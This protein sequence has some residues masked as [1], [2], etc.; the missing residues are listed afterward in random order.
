MVI[1]YFLLKG[2]TL[3]PEDEADSAQTSVFTQQITK[4]HISEDSN[5]HTQYNCE[6]FRFSLTH[7]GCYSK[8]IFWVLPLLK[9]TN[10]Y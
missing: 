3:L 10:L 6:R 7:S 4:H 9:I 1:C 8:E 2:G 5:F